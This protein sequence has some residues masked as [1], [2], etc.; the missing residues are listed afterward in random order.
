VTWIERE[1]VIIDERLDPTD[2]P[3][4]IGRYNFTVG[5]ETGHW[6]L[7]RKYFLKDPNQGELF[8]ADRGPTIVCRTSQAREPIEWQ[9]DYFSSCFLMPRALLCE[10]WKSNR[11]SLGSITLTE[12]KA[13]MARK[14]IAKDTDE[15]IIEKFVAP[16]AKDFAVSPIAMRIRLENVGL[17]VREERLPFR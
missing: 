5:H 14:N 1:Q 10:A 8:D 13:A 11:N 15:A 12:L 6:Q 3:E 7:H 9:A 2:H 4:M 16:L 17:V